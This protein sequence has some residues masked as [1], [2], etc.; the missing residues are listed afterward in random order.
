MKRH[1][2]IYLVVFCAILIGAVTPTVHDTRTFSSVITFSDSITLGDHTLDGDTTDGYLD[3]TL[4][5]NNSEASFKRFNIFAGDHTTNPGWRIIQDGDV[6]NLDF[7]HDASGLRI[8]HIY[9][10]SNGSFFSYAS[11]NR[12]FCESDGDVSIR[13]NDAAGADYFRVQDSGNNDIWTCDSDGNV[14]LTTGSKTVIADGGTSA[15]YILHISHLDISETV[16]VYEAVGQSTVTQNGGA[17]NWYYPLNIESRVLGAKV[18][19]DRIFTHISDADADDYLDNIELYS[20]EA[21]STTVV[22]ASNSDNKTSAGS[23]EMLE[24][25]DVTLAD[26]LRYHLPLTGAFATNGDFDFTGFTIHYH[27]E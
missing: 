25:S 2:Y 3:L 15:P 9:S 5:S 20:V 10:D 6:G 19:I 7:L 26:D 17:C 12:V 27:L 21:D 22:V 18:V 24:G 11:L 14:T 23:Y 4:D 8:L 1:D 13:L 16:S